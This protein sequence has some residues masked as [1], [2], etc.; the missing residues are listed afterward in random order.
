MTEELTTLQVKALT[1]L[2][3]HRGK[4]TS[5]IFSMDAF[6]ETL[7][8]E[9]NEVRFQEDLDILEDDDYVK[10]V[11]QAFGEIGGYDI[12]PKGI[13]YLRER[14]GPMNGLN[15]CKKKLGDFLTA[16]RKIE[17]EGVSSGNYPLAQERLARWKERAIEFLRQNV[18]DAEAAKLSKKK[19]V[20]YIGI[21][22]SKDSFVRTVDKYETHFLALLEE[23]E[24]NPEIILRES[25]KNN[26]IQTTQPTVLEGKRVFLIHGRD[27]GAKEKT[28]RFLEKVGLKPIILHEQPNKGRT[29]IEKIE[30]NSNVAYA[31]VLLTADDVGG[32]GSGK[33]NLQPRGRQNVVFEFGFFMGKLKRDRVCALYQKGVEKPSDIDG[34]V[35]IPLDK[36]GAWKMELAKELKS[37]GFDIDLN[38]FLE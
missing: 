28:A 30:R 33:P 26:A 6:Y 32:I 36:N 17:N 37:A 25:A 5:K 3:E 21:G 12:K 8:D 4:S 19:R 38:K 13:K 18:S 11:A 16:L 29:I 22:L 23:I 15:D 35:Y 9:T 31:V 7:K 2:R 20:S 34:L 27:E 14:M 1:A 24:E 10:K